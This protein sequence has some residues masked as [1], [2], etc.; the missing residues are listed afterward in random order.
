MVEFDHLRLSPNLNGLDGI[1]RQMAQ[2]FGYTAEVSI[3]RRLANL[4]RLRVAQLNPCSYCLILHTQVALESG[5]DSALVAHLPSWRESAMLDPME[6]AALDYCEALTEFDVPRFDSA[7]RALALH[8][9]EPAIADIAAVVINMNV[10]T[11]LKLA[12]GVTPSP[13]H[14]H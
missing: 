14:N 3:P 6:V 1:A 7:H 11:R 8:F 4:L 13:A 9:S 12:Q 5:L 2:Q 10:W